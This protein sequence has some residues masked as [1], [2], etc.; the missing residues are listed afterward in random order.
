MIVVWAHLLEPSNFEVNDF[1][2]WGDDGA[3]V[4]AAVMAATSVATTASGRGLGYIDGGG[5]WGRAGHCG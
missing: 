4:G 3:P 2:V 1:W 5:D